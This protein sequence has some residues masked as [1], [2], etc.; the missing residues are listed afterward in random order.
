LQ[1]EI[2][3]Y[4]FLQIIVLMCFEHYFCRPCKQLL[5]PLN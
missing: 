2:Y 3:Q 1:P 4:G 5:N